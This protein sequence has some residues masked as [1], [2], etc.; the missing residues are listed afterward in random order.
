MWKGRLTFLALLAMLFL[1]QLGVLLAFFAPEASYCCAVSLSTL[2]S[3]FYSAK[4]LSNLSVSSRYCCMWLFVPKCRIWHFPLSCLRFCLPFS[5][6]CWGPSEQQHDH[7]ANE[8]LQVLCHLQTVKVHSE[9][10][11][12]IFTEDGR[13]LWSTFFFLL[14]QR[15]SF[16]PLYAW[17]EF[18]FLIVALCFDRSIQ[19]CTSGFECATAEVAQWERYRQHE[20]RNN[21]WKT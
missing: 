10:P 14:K 6:A 18:I 2:T 21:S 17:L 9:L 1:T 7:L 13:L 16:P 11:C 4:L 8:Q 20:A 12:R 15:S 3:R 19:W 5:P